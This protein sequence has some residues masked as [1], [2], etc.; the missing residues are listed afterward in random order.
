MKTKLLRKVRRNFR[1]VQNEFGNKKV[2]ERWL[3]WWEDLSVWDIH[4]IERDHHPAI[5]N[6]PILVLRV[7]LEIRYENFSRKHKIINKKENTW[8]KIWYK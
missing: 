4:L 5:F 2:Q 7:L 1:I 8:T 3:F 6:N